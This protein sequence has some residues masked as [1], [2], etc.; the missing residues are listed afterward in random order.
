MKRLT[1]PFLI[2]NYLFLVERAGLTRP[3]YNV[4][5]LTLALKKEDLGL[6]GKTLFNSLE[7]VSIKLYPQIQRIKEWLL[8]KQVQS[9]LMSGSGPAVFGV[10]SSRKEAASLYRQLKRNNRS[11]RVFVVRTI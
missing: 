7:P 10:V 4:K 11:W 8:R 2:L 9:I 3:E 1:P 5:L 6:I